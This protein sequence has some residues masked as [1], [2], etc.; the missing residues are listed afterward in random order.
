MMN[1]LKALLKQ[2][3][4]VIALVLG[5]VLVALPCVTIDK[6]NH[7]AT[8][9]PNTF[10]LVAFGGALLLLSAVGFALTLWTKYSSD[11][12]G[13]LD[14]TRVKE[15]NGVMSTTVSGCEI[16]V[17]EGRLEGYAPDT[18]TTIVLPC[19][20]YFDDRCAGDTKSAL[21]AR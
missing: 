10:A 19:N 12:A 21:G 17:V 4:W 7:L 16:R 1:V 20:E 15:T 8:H 13:G 14:L 6:D 9:P 2:P 3:Y 11:P 18:G 5:V